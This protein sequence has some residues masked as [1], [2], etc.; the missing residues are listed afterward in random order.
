M[1]YQFSFLSLKAILQPASFRGHLGFY[2]NFKMAYSC[3]LRLTWPLVQ[4]SVEKALV[5]ENA[6]ITWV[7][8]VY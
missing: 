8:P 5:E 2:A 7:C 4:D 6:I 1:I 3:L